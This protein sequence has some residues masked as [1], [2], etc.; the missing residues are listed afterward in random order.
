M[1]SCLIHSVDEPAIEIWAQEMNGGG[2]WRA[3]QFPH[4]GNYTLTPGCAFIDHFTSEQ[5][6]YSILET[7]VTEMLSTCSG[8]VSV[9]CNVVSSDMT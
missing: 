8:F 3:E 1:K 5:L 9:S 7:F 6:P 2:V 4:L